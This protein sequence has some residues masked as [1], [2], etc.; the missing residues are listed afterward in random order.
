MR[1]LAVV[2]RL[3]LGVLPL[4]VLIATPAVAAAGGTG[5]T[6]TMTTTT[7][8]TNPINDVNPCAPA[9]PV[10]GVSVDNAVMHITF[11]PASDEHWFTFTDTA[12]VTVTDQVTGVVYT[13]HSTFWANDNLNERNANFTFTSTINVRGSDGSTIHFHEVGH[14]TLNANGDVTVS[15]DRPS[16]TC[17]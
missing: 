8:S 17:G 12:K 15:F 7:K 11:F 6:V 9:D 3:A 16:V 4:T 14:L 13:G 2:A 1:C 10:V 5:H